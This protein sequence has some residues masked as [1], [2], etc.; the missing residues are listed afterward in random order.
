MTAIDMPRDG[1]GHHGSMRDVLA[2]R[3]LSDIPRLL[4]LQDRTPVSA[5]YGSFDRN[6]WLYRI[7]DFPSGMAQ[8][9]VLTLALV[10]SLDMPGNPYFRQE[11]IR[12]WTEA[13][14][15]YAA[16]SAHADGSC[17]DYYP[18]ERASGA[19]AF[20]L[21]ACLDAA[22]IIGVLDDP[23]I[24]AF[25]KRR[26]SW[27]ARHRESGQ[28]ANHEALVAA[29]LVRMVRHFGEEW[30]P[31]FRSRLAT[32]LSWQTAEGWFQEYEGAD[33]GY[34][35]LTIAQLADIDRRRPDLELRPACRS[36]ISFVAA[37]QHPDGSLGGE[38][39][40]R[41]TLNYFPHG[42]EIAGAWCPEA[43]S[44]NDR[45]LKLLA[46]GDNPALNDDR[47]F[48]HHL[49]SWLLAWR[50]WQ[51]VRPG[52]SAPMEGRTLFPLAR[53]LVDV[54]D[55]QALYLG[56]D[57][58]GA[59]RLFRKTRLIA[60]DTGPT[61]RMAD[62]RIAV[63]QLFLDP[64]LETENGDIVITGRLCWAGSALL[65]PAKSVILRLAMLT[66]GR[67][68]P[69]LMRRA[70]QKLLVTGRR[71]A[72]FRLARRLAWADGGWTVRDEV[73]AEDGWDKVAMAGIGGFQ[74]ATVTVMSQVWEPAQLQPWIDLTGRV[75]AL[76]A[77][78]PL[79][80]ER[81]LGDNAPCDS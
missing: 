27:L 53:M 52:V 25:L 7:A 35:T 71:A 1:Q 24:S 54:R 37:L 20:S 76:K 79:V 56:W 80:I 68:F 34:L 32:L 46:L 69:N 21:L 59:F 41:G 19:A 48:G 44:L 81:R 28:L 50:E 40:S 31:L 11:R 17:D 10:W 45:A 3:A 33:P 16:R 5:T 38:Y 61:F 55:G 39:A 26:A 74:C 65:T 8:K 60:A 66:V 22:E 58:G 36:A 57:R 6:H 51:P 49:A 78:A 42:L 9:H 70:L 75:R 14:I 15:R 12:A 4:T 73:T 43:T 2:A 62:G 67:F 64:A 29:C 13:G 63:S 77:G 47:L 30:E 23:E 72:P 18:F